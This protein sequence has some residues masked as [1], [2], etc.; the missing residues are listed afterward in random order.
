MHWPGFTFDILII[1]YSTESIIDQSDQENEMKTYICMNCCDCCVNFT[2]EDMH[3][4]DRIQGMFTHTHTRLFIFCIHDRCSLNITLQMQLLHHKTFKQYTSRTWNLFT[5]GF[6]RSEFQGVPLVWGNSLLNLLPEFFNYWTS[7]PLLQEAGRSPC[8][9]SACIADLSHCWELSA[10]RLRTSLYLHK[11]KNWHLK[12]LMV[13]RSLKFTYAASNLSQWWKCYLLYSFGS[14]C[15]SDCSP[16]GSDPCLASLMRS[17]YVSFH[18]IVH[19]TH[20][21][22]FYYYR[23]WWL[24]IQ[25]GDGLAEWNGAGRSG[26]AHAMLCVRW[27]GHATLTLYVVRRAVS[28]RSCFSLKHFCI[29]AQW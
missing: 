10:Y 29:R 27:W 2:I 17:A 20:H 1:F 24:S 22:F 18:Q 3:N 13:T 11:Q 14:L 5:T 12:K 8:F 9:R 7:L 25:L 23:H 15:V 16:S 4:I 6:N 19:A 28:G 26:I 21:I